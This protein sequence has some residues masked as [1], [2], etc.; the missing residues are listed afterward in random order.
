MRIVVKVGTS[1]LA[2]PGGLLNIRHT[3]DLV[4]VWSDIQNAGHQLI[5]VSSA[6]TGLGAGKLQIEKPSDLVTKQAAAAVGQLIVAG[7]FPP[8]PMQPINFDA[9]YGETLR[10]RVAQQAGGELAN[11]ETAG[12]A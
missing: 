5:V 12:N 7:G 3:E 10:Q 11:T 2:H 4:R 9:L 8:F 6:A 1:T